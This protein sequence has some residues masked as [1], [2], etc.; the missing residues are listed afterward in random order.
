[1]RYKFAE[2]GF[3]KRTAGSFNNARDQPG[4]GANGEIDGRLAQRLQPEHAI[5]AKTRGRGA[6]LPEGVTD[7]R[8]AA[9]EKRHATCPHPVRILCAGPVKEP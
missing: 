9:A 3:G 6:D 7:R 4:M 1:L 8:I 5:A 2:F